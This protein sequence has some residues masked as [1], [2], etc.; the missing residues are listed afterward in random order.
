MTSSPD[1]IHELRASRP[2][3]PLALRARV[4]EIAAERPARAARTNWRFPVRRGLL[5]AVPAAAALAFASAGVLGLARSDVSS[6]EALRAQESLALEALPARPASRPGQHA[7]R[8]AIQ[9]ATDAR[10]HRAQRDQRDTH[11]RGLG[12]RRRLARSAGRARPH[13]HA[14]R[15]R[16]LVVGG[17]R[18]TKE[19][20]RSPSAFRSGRCRTRSRDC[21][22]SGASS[23]SRSRSTTCRR[24]STSSSTARRSSGR[25][26][27]ASAHGCR[28]SRSTPRPKRCSRPPADAP[29]RADGVARGHLDVAPTPRHA[30]R[31]SS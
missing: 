21:P 3:A 13:P 12:R 25:R 17:D 27:R 6:T 23:R 16:R 4:R 1:L 30:C 15:L 9:G 10:H 28:P 14:R 20:R 18:A 22:G 5:V 26:S 2:S 31:R 8:P 19:A 11:R 29:G 7:G 24:R